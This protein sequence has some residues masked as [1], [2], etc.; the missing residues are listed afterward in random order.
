MDVAPDGRI[1]ALLRVRRHLPRFHEV[2]PIEDDFVAIFDPSGRELRRF[3]LLEALERSRYAPLLAARPAW[4]DLLHTNEIEILDSNRL[5]IR[6]PAFAE[7]NLLVSFREID[8]VAVVDPQTET[9]VWALTGQWRRQL[10]SERL[11]MAEPLPNGNVLVV[12]STAGRALEVTRSGDVVWE[13][14]NPY[15]A[16]ES[17]E[18]VATLF[19][20][21]R[22]PPEC[23][24][25]FAAAE[26]SA[27]R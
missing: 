4:G 20:L 24:T 11:G 26:R 18:L 23:C 22:L 1:F 21:R 15:R 13:F 27:S 7:G 16:G 14:S 12:E 6:H 3:S 10:R 9:V 17:G 2:Q 25:E 5:S 19:V 8:T